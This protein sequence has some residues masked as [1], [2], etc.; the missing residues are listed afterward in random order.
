M[1]RELWDVMDDYIRSLEKSADIQ[2]VKTE[3]MVDVSALE[4]ELEELRQDCQTLLEQV[5]EAEKDSSSQ[6]EQNTPISSPI[7]LSNMDY[8]DNGNGTSGSRGYFTVVTGSYYKDN[9]GDEYTK[10]GRC[11]VLLTKYIGIRY[12]WGTV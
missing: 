5:Q 12:T 3:D 4:Q 10:R 1:K 6:P 7:Y 11:F 2:D 8:Y 9:T